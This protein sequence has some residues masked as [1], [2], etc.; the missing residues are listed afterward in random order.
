MASL[1]SAAFTNRISVYIRACTALRYK[2][3]AFSRKVLFLHKYHPWC[4]A[5]YSAAVGLTALLYYL[6]RHKHDFI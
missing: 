5:L 1:L 3:M 4:H 6:Y 2:K